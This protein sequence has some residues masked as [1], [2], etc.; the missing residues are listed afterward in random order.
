MSA[1]TQDP[2]LALPTEHDAG[3]EG[4]WVLPVDGTE[5]A[6]FDGVFLGL[7][8]SGPRGH[9][10]HLPGTWAAPGQ[11]CSGCRWVEIRLYRADGIYY[12]HFAGRSAVPDEVTRFKVDWADT[13]KAVIE[14][15]TTR[16]GGEEFFSVPAQQL[17]DRVASL[18]GTP[19]DP[20]LRAAYAEVA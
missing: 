3:R 6:A 9:Q 14:L 11:R 17:L 16:R 1:M 4:H 13:P 5:S 12:V 18:D 20:A 2:E 10:R 8:A 15:L 7:G 19:L